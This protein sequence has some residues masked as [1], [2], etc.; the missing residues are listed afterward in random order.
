[1]NIRLLRK[2][3]NGDKTYAS[4][5]LLS[6]GDAD[7]RN[8]IRQGIAEKHVSGS[9]IAGSGSDV[10]AEI[11][12]ALAELGGRNHNRLFS[13]DSVEGVDAKS[14]WV[15]DEYPGGDGCEFNGFVDFL[16]SVE[17]ASHGRWDPRL[18]DLSEGVDSEGGFTIPLQ[19]RNQLMKEVM[20]SSPFF[21]MATLL[22][23][24]ASSEKIP[25]IYDADR[26]S[27]GLHGISIPT[28]TEASALTDISPSFGSFQLTLHKIGGR[29]RVSNE[30][31]EDSSLSL[32]TLL[33]AVFSEALSFNMQ[34]QFIS[35]SGANESL[36]ILNGPATITVAKEDGQTADTIDFEN[37]VNIWSRLLPAAQRRA[38]WLASPDT[39]P[40]L[41]TM[42]VNI[43]TAG[44]HVFLPRDAGATQAVPSTIFGRPLYFSECCPKLGDEGDIM[45]FDPQ[46][47][48]IG[49]KPNGL[50][51]IE[52]SEHARFE[53]DQTVFRAVARVDGQ[54]LMSSPITPANSGSTLSRFVKL[55]ERS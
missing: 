52:V 11:Q 33:P 27:T 20:E 35:G 37:I 47:F 17:G 44:S 5:Q 54:P 19:L 49:K 48:A 21:S 10:K 30:M 36:G 6:M 4:G 42:T 9:I 2:W 28:A 39:I 1:M 8:L 51:R 12:K 41:F 18:K 3:V 40:Q 53:N 32:S 15:G 38:I 26:S 24:S 16:K 22:P 46:A 31:L 50:I 23:M 29:C 34:Q 45:L 55:A 7:G 43:G 14:F 25:Y 13:G